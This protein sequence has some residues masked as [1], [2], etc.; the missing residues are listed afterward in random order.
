MEF[1]T[2][3]YETLSAMTKYGGSFIKCLA[4]LYHRADSE[5]QAILEKAFEHYFVQYDEM[6]Q[7]IFMMKIQKGRKF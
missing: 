6:A 7:S 2:S 1:R 5:N 3:K 4:E